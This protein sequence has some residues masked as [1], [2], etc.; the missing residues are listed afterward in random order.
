[1]PPSAPVSEPERQL[2]LDALRGFALLGIL[3]MNIRIF[4]MPFAAYFNPTAYGSLDGANY[5]VWFLSHVFF[6]QKFMTIFS[7]LFGAGIVL[8]TGRAEARGDRPAVRHY[9]R[10]FWLLVFGLIHAYGLWYGDILVLYALCGLWVFL[11]RSRSP[12]T[13]L[14]VGALVLVVGSL[15]SIG[16]YFGIQQLPPGEVAEIERHM[17]RPVPEDLARE[18]ANYRSGWWGQMPDRVTRSLE[19]QLQVSV[20][21]GLWR[22][23][24][25]MLIGMAL[26]KQGVFTGRASQRLYV[27][28]VAGGALIGLPL[29]LWGMRTTQLRG[30]D[31]LEAF[32]IE[33]QWNY[34][35][36]LFL[37][38]GYVG[39]VMLVATRGIFNRLIARLAA[40]GRMALTNYLLHTII[41]TTVFY[42]HG[43][44]Y[45]G[46]FSR[47]DQALLVI[48][49]WVLQ[50]VVSPIWLRHFAF[51]PFEWVWRALTYGHAPPFRRATT[52]AASGVA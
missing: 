36:S 7:M 23:G 29:I 33:G 27:V 28:F 52:Q 42:G 6:D 41:C 39:L 24:G 25:L 5:W 4:S 34:W 21:W 2:P 30:W 13:L 26:F 17:V 35:G 14:I 3:M 44:G 45:F 49:V 50:L 43:L 8:M 46:S 32:F 48:G 11:L 47:T 10:M 18:I 22:A 51:G 38:L 31:S 9:R 19:F 15:L 1:M 37:S 12:R 40:V 16:G 20:L